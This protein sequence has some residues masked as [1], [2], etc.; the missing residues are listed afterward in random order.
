MRVSV[1]KN[2]SI[3]ILR[4]FLFFTFLR[5]NFQGTEFEV[6]GLATLSIFHSL[7]LACMISKKLNLFSAVCKTICLSAVF[8][9]FV[10][11][12]PGWCS[13]VFLDLQFGTD[14]S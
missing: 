6:G 5:T 10:Y 1:K 11:I 3:F 14:I 2:P 13:L 9:L 4:K 8:H 7:S 12:Y